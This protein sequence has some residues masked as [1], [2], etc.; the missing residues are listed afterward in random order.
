E[1]ENAA[2]WLE[3]SRAELTRNMQTDLLPDGVQ[4]ELSLDYHHIVLRNYLSARRLSLM[5]G[6]PM[7]AEM[8]ALMRKALEFSMYAH[9]PAGDTPAVSDGDRGKFLYLLEQGHQLY[10]SQDLLYVA[11]QGRRGAAP[12]RRSV[13]F[14]SSG[15][16][17]LRSG[18]GE[19]ARYQDEQYLLF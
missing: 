1:F 5:N 6:I 9:T 16:V 7:P 19:R 18:W 10:G 13:S 11:T 4:C 2:E 17:V 14:P 15:Y 8:D 3:F 12:A